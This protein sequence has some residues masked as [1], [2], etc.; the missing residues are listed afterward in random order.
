MVDE[1]QLFWG[2][3]YPMS[4]RDKLFTGQDEL[5]IYGPVR[6]A[7]VPNDDD[8]DHQSPDYKAQSRRYDSVLE[9]RVTERC[10]LETRLVS[11]FFDRFSTIFPNVTTV[12]LRVPSD[13]Y[14]AVIKKSSPDITKDDNWY[15]SVLPGKGDWRITGGNTEQGC[16]V[17]HDAG[18][19]PRMAK[20]N[21]KLLNR[22]FIREL[23]LV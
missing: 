19:F 8:D 9:E 15:A 23:K 1:L 22:T 16:C 10:E 17:K 18:D 20:S 13:L 2:H 7:I 12:K 3:Y 11:E 14:A 4:N 21:R 5:K 6:N